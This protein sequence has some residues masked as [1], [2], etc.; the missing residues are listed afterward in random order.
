MTV[1]GIIQ[2]IMQLTKYDELAIEEAIKK[3]FG[4]QLEVNHMIASDLPISHTG[5]AYVFLSEKK[6]LYLYIHAHSKYSLGDMSKI[7][8]RMGLKVEFTFPP[9][10]QPHYFNDIATKKFT[11]VFPGRKPVSEDDLRFYKTLVPY[12]PALFMIEEVKE[13]VIK[14]FDSDSPGRWR[15]AKKFAYRRIRTS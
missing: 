3:A 8:T 14:Q 10:G 4:V 15:S 9:K 7:A 5:S 6:Q 2:L 11:E 13:G 1:Y 12:N